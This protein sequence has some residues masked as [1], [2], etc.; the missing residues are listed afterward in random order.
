MRLTGTSDP[1]ETEKAARTYR[2]L[3]EKKATRL[4]LKHLRQRGLWDAFHAL[5]EQ[6]NTQLE[7]PTLTKLHKALVSDGDFAA[8]EEIL[9]SSCQEDLFSEYLD[10]CCCVATWKRLL[11]DDGVCP[12]VRGGHQ[13]CIDHISDPSNPRYGSNDFPFVF[14]N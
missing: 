9:H 13:L 1:E 11:P 4:C 14:Q 10:G 3:C 5:Q 7:H 8:T 2:E 6:T 12:G